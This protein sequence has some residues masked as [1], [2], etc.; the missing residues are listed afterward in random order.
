[1]KEGL[2]MRKETRPNYGQALG[3]LKRVY[4]HTQNGGL[5][6]VNITHTSKSNMS[7]SSDATIYYTDT[8]GRVDYL[9]LNWMFSTLTDY[10]LDKNGH[11]KGNGCGIDRRFLLAYELQQLFAFHGMPAELPRYR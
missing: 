4:G 5:L 7:Y 1:M 3:L 9:S 2:E 11:L 6:I 10:K 8:A